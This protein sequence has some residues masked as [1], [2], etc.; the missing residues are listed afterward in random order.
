[1]MAKHAFAA[2]NAPGTCLWCGRKLRKTWKFQRYGKL[3]AYADGFFAVC[4]ARTHGRL[5]SLALAID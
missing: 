5:P 2:S 1:M 4:R 3:G